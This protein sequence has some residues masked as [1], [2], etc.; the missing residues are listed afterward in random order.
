M[1]FHKDFHYKRM[2][3]FLRM[4]AAI[5]VH[6][7]TIVTSHGQVHLRICKESLKGQKIL[8]EQNCTKASE[9]SEASAKGKFTSHLGAAQV[10]FETRTSTLRNRRRGHRCVTRK[11]PDHVALPVGRKGT[12]AVRN[13]GPWV[14]E[15]PQPPRSVVAVGCHSFKVIQSITFVYTFDILLYLSPEVDIL[16]HIVT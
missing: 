14:E 13:G 5:H 7:D 12:S 6:A 8:K 16:C 3:T 9:A 10:F 11:G 1:V 15:M 4:P 2:D